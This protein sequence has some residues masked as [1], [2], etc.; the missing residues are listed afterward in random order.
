M[1]IAKKM[2]NILIIFLTVVSVIFIGC[3]VYFKLSSTDIFT[4]QTS[5]YAIS[6]TDPVTNEELSPL[7]ASY[8]QNYNNT[9][10]EVV[11][12]QIR[13]YSDQN[14]SAIYRRGFQYIID[15][16]NGNELWFYDT[17]DRVS[18]ESGHKYNEKNDS[19]QL[20]EAYFIELDG[21]IVGVRMD[22]TYEKEVTTVNGTNIAGN[23]LLGP[24]WWI[25]NG[26]YED[27]SETV[28]ETH[29]YTMEEFMQELADIIKSSSA[30]T[31]DYTLPVIDLGDFL[32]LYEVDENGT[33][34]DTP[35]GAG[36]Q[37]NSYFT[38]DVHNDRRGMT[39][40][41]QS[42]FGI[43][44]NDPDFNISGIDF[45]SEIWKTTV[46]YNLDERDFISRF[47]NAESG[48][49]YSLS[50]ETIN[51]LKS[52]DNLDV[53]IV[54]DISNLIDTNVLGFDYYSLNGIKVHSLTIT[55]DIKC[56]FTL[57]A[58]A[59]KDT[60][61]TKIYTTNIEINNISGTEVEYEVV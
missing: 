54:F 26:F 3:F 41:G 38:M 11:E 31:G 6:V 52:F 53:E 61:L 15:E 58:G 57:L 21:E 40:A 42:M 46:V 51:E 44:A 35:I 19:G 49:Y 37:I 32:H 24:V 1:E 27:L 16:E 34:S 39:Y 13:A 18:W 7:S 12:F 17:Y 4:H 2:L 28:K 47:S 8:Y 20:R 56:N 25:F 59:L 60:G 45:D 43:V 22:G 29:Y 14:K 30:G 5:T 9:G 23:I 33:V 10:K 55:S 50:S 48:Y 36:G